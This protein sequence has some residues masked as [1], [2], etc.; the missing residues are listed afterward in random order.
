MSKVDTSPEPEMEESFLPEGYKVPESTNGFMKFG[1]GDNKFRFLTKP[2][3]GMS[4]WKD[5]DG[6]RVP[7]RVRAGET[8]DLSGVDPK[9]KPR[10]FW[11]AVVWDYQADDVMLL[12]ISQINIL[13]AIASYAQ[14]PKWGTPKGYDLVVNRT[15]DT[16]E[17]T[18]YFVAAEPKEALP[19]DIVDTFAQYDVNLD[20]FFDGGNVLNAKG[21]VPASASAEPGKE[22][23]LD[24]IPFG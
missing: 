7:Y 11:A 3:M 24:D 10:H 18:K 8:M 19:Q 14:N 4:F 9:E 21:V 17:T 23:N 2:V 15:G 13:R 22:I 20:A 1:A 6:K 16:K 12:E 5:E